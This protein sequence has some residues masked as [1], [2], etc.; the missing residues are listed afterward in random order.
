MIATRKITGPVTAT[1]ATVVLALS[2]AAPAASAMPA[3]APLAPSSSATTTA[4]ATTATSASA[5]RLRAALTPQVLAAITTRLAT[6]Q[7]EGVDA[8]TPTPAIAARVAASTCGPTELNSWL[9]A[10]ISGLTEVDLLLASVGGQ[11]VTIDAALFGSSS[12]P[13][14]ALTS[15]RQTLTK[16]YAR[17]VGF[18]D[19]DIRDVDLLAMHGSMLV[20]RARVMRLLTELGGP[21][22]DNADE[23]VDAIVDYFAGPAMR[24]G[25]LPLITFN[26]FAMP[27]S[28]AMPGV[29]AAPPKV[30]IGD[31]ILA[32]YDALGLGDVAP[33][34]TLSHE[35]AHQVQ[36]DLGMFA[37][38]EPADPAAATRRTEL[39]ADASAAYLL[40]HPRGLSMQRKRVQAFER[41]FFD[42]GD[43]L[44]D[45][46]GHHGTPIQRAAA[47]DWGY[48]MQESARPKSMIRPAAVLRDRFDAAGLTS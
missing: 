7:A 26:A 11:L 2:L 39:H 27:G 31:G 21:P 6:L 23:I 32:A 19:P 35:M 28:D 29:P 38:P 5:A 30:V 47:A 46:P 40:S 24:G 9:G 12:D 13:A 4:V 43:C 44:F 3:V 41:V 48:R 18:W 42:V 1:A 37:G 20:D 14:Y 15:H 25:E 36:F 17:D 16:T 10:Q 45:N 34:A 22:P 33:Q 8:A